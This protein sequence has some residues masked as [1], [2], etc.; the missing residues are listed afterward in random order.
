MNPPI[1]ATWIAGPTSQYV[2]WIDGVG[3]YLLCLSNRVSLGQPADQKQA[4]LP[5]VAD[6]SRQHA[7]IHREAEGYFLEA[8]RKT[9][10][11][12]QTVEKTWLRSGDRVTLGRACQLRFTQP[13]PVSASARL[14]LESGHRWLRPVEAVLLMAETVVLGPGSQSHVVIADLPQPIIFY[15][16]KDGLA[17]RYAGDLAINGQACRQRGDLPLG[18]RIQADDWSMTLEAL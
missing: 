15:R 12:G 8:A 7:T 9:Q 3:G 17:V 14:D 13:A 16:A 10:V 11:N 1:S 2:L 18:A 5:I 6:L 4:D